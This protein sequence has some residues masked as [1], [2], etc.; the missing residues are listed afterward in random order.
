MNSELI[1]NISGW[2]MENSNALI[3][4]SFPLPIGQAVLILLI[5]IT[6]VD[7]GKVKWGFFLSYIFILYW[8]VVANKLLFATLL[9]GNPVALVI[10]V[11]AGLIVT[12]LI[13]Y[14]FFQE[15]H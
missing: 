9:A 1:S 4:K 3:G 15:S 8:V 6:C 12:L 7:L 13:F 5:A 10:Y 14:G 11:F 2:V